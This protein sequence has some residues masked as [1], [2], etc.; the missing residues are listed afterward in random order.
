[1]EHPFINNLSDK[2]LEQLQDAITG[3][4]QKLNFAYRTQNSPLINQLRM[5]IESYQTE[6]QKKI[7]DLIKKQNIGDQVRIT[8]AK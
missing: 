6:Y 8:K 7:N 1:M 4:N 3:L 5:A 2:S